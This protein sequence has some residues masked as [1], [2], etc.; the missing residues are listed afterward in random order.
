MDV[1]DLLNR[2]FERLGIEAPL[3]LER[4]TLAAL[5]LVVALVANWVAKRVLL[6]ALRALV[7]RSQTD[8]DDELVRQRVFERLSQLAPALVV[9]V[10][11]PLIFPGE[12]EE[13]LRIGLQR[14]ANLWMVLVGASAAG[15]LLDALGNIFSSAPATRDKP[16]RSYVQVAKIVLWLAAGIIAVATLIN[17]SP[18]SLLGGLGAMTAVLLLVFKDS[19]LG[20]V[21]SV[22]IAAY[23]LARVGDWIEVPSHGADGDVIEISLH[24]V[25]VQNWDKTIV[26]LPT[27]ALLSSGFKNWRGMSESGGRRIKRA[28]ILDMTSARFLDEDDIERLSQVQLLEDYIAERQA[29]VAR[30][31]DE[32]GIE[33]TSP[34]NGRRLTN[35]GTF[36]AYVE[37]FLRAN[38]PVH[39]EM[40]FLVRQLAPTAEGLP[41]ELYFFSSEQR[42][43][44]YE[45]IIADIF[46]HLL[47]SLPEFGLRV[48]QKPSG[49][50][51]RAGWGMAKATDP[52]S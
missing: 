36:R 7:R 16:V 13:A 10:S 52:P 2:A 38:F 23:D 28:L 41:L 39:P 33:S 29:E 26:S 32:R 6:R 3:W 34:I 37:G 47:A 25:K 20:F 27:V 22:Q 44:E 1:L 50:D 19:I 14:L 21:A 24:T 43:A 46:D 35:L 49:A 15:A 48:F 40:T 17:K 30:W 8:W 9:F 4:L 11:A 12:G 31:N 45:G 18:W 5:V 42:W 51:M